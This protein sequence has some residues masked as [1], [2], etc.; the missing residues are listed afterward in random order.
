MHATTIRL[1]LRGPQRKPQQSVYCIARALIDSAMQ[2]SEH[3][4]EFFSLRRADDR[5]AGVHA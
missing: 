2:N 5:K 1:T 4:F 3:D